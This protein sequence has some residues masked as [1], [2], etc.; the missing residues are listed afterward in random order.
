MENTFRKRPHYY[1]IEKLYTELTIRMLPALA[2]TRLT[3]NQVTLANY[4]N[5]FLIM[6]LITT[7]RFMPAALLIQVYLFLDIVDGN[8]A[9]YTG[10][11][12][13]LGQILDHIGDRFFYNVVMIVLGLAT[14]VHWGWIAAFLVIH[15][16]YAAATTYYIVPAI[17]RIAEF[18]R[19]GLKKI[20]MDRGLLLGMDLSTQALIISVLIATPWR[21]Q[22]LP[23]VTALYLADLLFR[24]FELA[25]NRHFLSDR[26]ASNRR[27]GSGK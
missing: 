17:R 9:R 14:P 26:N 11:T 2:R 24:L 20:L 7:Q 12:T 22:I 13:R 8:L 5:G 23:S 6:F 27:G 4:A 3:P 21:G 16:T 18:R 25:R 15:N 10:K 1:V 19:F